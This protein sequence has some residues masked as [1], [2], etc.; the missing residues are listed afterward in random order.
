MKIKKRVLVSFDGECPYY[1][2]H[3]YTYSL[4]KQTKHRSLEEIVDSIKNEEFDVIYVSQRKENFVSPDE[5]LEL[6]EAL[7]E[8]YHTNIVAITRNVFNNSHLKRLKVLSDRMINEGNTFFLCSSVPGLASAAITEDLSIVPSP[9]DRINFLRDVYNEGIRTILIIRPLYPK[10]I[11]PTDE[12]IELI[13]KCKLFVSCVLSSGLVVNNDI[14]R[15][16]NYKETDF[17][18]T[19][20][21]QSDYLVG[22]IEDEMK[23]IN[24]KEELEE[25]K[26][27]CLKIGVPFFE[28]S[29]TAIN[30]LK[31]IE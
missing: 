4:D 8:R 18:Y 30:Y 13:N 14:L 5:G 26:K 23:Y 1:C 17:L 20:N 16:L 6:C 9:E 29:M 22:A 27:Y 21:G 19:D 12:I 11:I 7:Y 2:K 24:V 3:C 28:H 10:N 25:L 31:S 15:M